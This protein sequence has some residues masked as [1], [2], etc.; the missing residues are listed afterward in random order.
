MP[1]PVGLVFAFGTSVV[2]GVL[3]GVASTPLA[4]AGRDGRIIASALEAE[5]LARKNCTPV[6]AS[7]DTGTPQIGDSRGDGAY[8][9]GCNAWVKSVT[10]LVREGRLTLPRL[11]RQNQRH[12]A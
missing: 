8:L 7:S 3:G 9:C 2:S 11:Q 4:H 10:A 12:T 1:A 6:Y 5:E